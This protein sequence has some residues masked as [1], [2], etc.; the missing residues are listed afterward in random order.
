MPSQNQ[1]VRHT[2]SVRF[3]K[4]LLE[5]RHVPTRRLLYI[6][7]CGLVFALTNTVAQLPYRDTPTILDVTVEG[8]PLR[9]ELGLSSTA[10]G[11]GLWLRNDTLFSAR[12]AGVERY[13]AFKRLGDAT[14]MPYS[15]A[16]VTMSITSF[17][18]SADGRYIALGYEGGSIEISTDGGQSFLVV[19]SPTQH[20]VNAIAVNS[21]GSVAFGRVP[22]GDLFVSSDHGTTWIREELPKLL[23]DST[24]HALHGLKFDTHDILSF[25]TAVIP[26]AGQHVLKVFF[27]RQGA[28][29]ESV[30]VANANRAF[31]TDS[32]S[33]YVSTLKRIPGRVDDTGFTELVK[34][35]TRTGQ[36]D[37]AFSFVK[38]D[39][40]SPINTVWASTRHR[41]TMAIA[42]KILYTLTG[43]AWYQERVQL[44]S[45]GSMR[46]FV[47]VSNSD[48][49][50]VAGTYVIRLRLSPVLSVPRYLNAS[51]DSGAVLEDGRLA[52]GS[53]VYDIL[54]RVVHTNYAPEPAF[55]QPA[56]SGLYFVAD[57]KTGRVQSRVY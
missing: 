8:R 4:R 13:I 56:T 22:E 48:V 23:N 51:D 49:Y 26:K 41:L 45:Y 25:V 2:V 20:N 35:D 15:I 16:T 19:E 17:A 55:W 1:F 30:E 18:V 14:W 33:L 47:E 28:E 6:I 44:P 50:A 24:Y 21:K 39:D 36:V 37:T 40:L 38:E 54:G 34:V 43:T 29:W 3:T 27:R 57:S 42:G 32:S 5:G 52:P 10:S 46:L 9:E 31:F 7:C 11:A 12:F 53:V